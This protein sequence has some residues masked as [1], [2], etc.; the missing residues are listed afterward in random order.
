MSDSAQLTNII[1]DALH[2]EDTNLRE[3]SLGLLLSLRN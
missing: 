3:H 2:D 1:G